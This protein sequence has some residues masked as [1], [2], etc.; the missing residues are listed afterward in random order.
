MANLFRNEP[1]LLQ[2]D[3]PTQWPSAGLGTGRSEISEAPSLSRGPKGNDS[4]GG[5]G[6][7]EGESDPGERHLRSY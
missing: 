3:K 7:S 4:G 1:R 6:G 5:S 2:S